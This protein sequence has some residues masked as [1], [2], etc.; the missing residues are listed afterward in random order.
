MKNLKQLLRDESGV[1]VI[2]YV[3]LASMGVAGALVVGGGIE[4]ATGQLDGYLNSAA[5]GMPT[6]PSFTNP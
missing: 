4:F 1:G 5:I 2:E 3:V 6:S